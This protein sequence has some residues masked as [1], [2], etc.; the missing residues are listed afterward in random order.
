MPLDLRSA[1]VVPLYKKG[2]KTLEGNYRSVSV[3]SIVSK[4]LERLVSEQVEAYLKQNNIM[5]EYQSGIRSGC[6]TDTCLIHLSDI[7]R[8]KMS[9]GLVNRNGHDRPTKSL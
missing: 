4:L 8:D 9:K 2:D 5:Y 6:S 3:L 7:I 1:R